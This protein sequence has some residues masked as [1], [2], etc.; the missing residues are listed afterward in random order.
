M[1]KYLPIVLIMAF[2]ST[3]LVGCDSVTM[4]DSLDEPAT[5]LHQRVNQ[6]YAQSGGFSG[7][8]IVIQDGEIILSDAF[9]VMNLETLAYNTLD[10]PFPIQPLTKMLTGTAILLLEADGALDTS[11][12]LDNFF[13]GHDNLRYITIS[14]LLSKSG[15]FG[16]STPL[17]RAFLA[18]PDYIRD[19]TP[20]E[21]EPYVLAHWRGGS[22]NCPYA[23]LDY[24]MLGRIIEQASGMSYEEFMQSRIFDLIGMENAGF[25]HTHEFA[26]PIQAHIRDY[27]SWENLMGTENF[28]FFLFYSFGGIVAS[29]NDLALWL[30]SFFGS[31]LFP[32]DMLTQINNGAF[33]Y[34]WMFHESGLWYYDRASGSSI[35]YDQ[36]SDTKI[37]V[38]SNFSTR[39]T[40][41]W[42]L[43]SA[44][45]ETLLNITIQ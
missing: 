45:A 2:I 15:G 19:M 12:T 10:T 31:K 20:Q 3:L 22:L 7:A 9:G 39:D 33:N 16:G 32:A 28:P 21:F 5:D 14:H 8:V 40:K 27:D 11:D 6:F 37:I 26:I 36:N 38:L 1:K 24:W 30:D 18:E 42:D 35:I 13:D 4:M 29:A 17:A 34:G 44:I 43:S 25:V 41:A 23:T